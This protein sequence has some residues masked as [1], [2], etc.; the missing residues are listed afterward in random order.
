[1]F[2]FLFFYFSPFQHI[3]WSIQDFTYNWWHGTRRKRRLQRPETVIKQLVAALNFTVFHR[4]T[5]AHFLGPIVWSQNYL[6]QQLVK[7]YPLPMSIH[8]AI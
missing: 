2:L 8:L 1:L 7:L 4:Y 5:S 6:F 3:I